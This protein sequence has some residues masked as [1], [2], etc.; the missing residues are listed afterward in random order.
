MS[1]PE[2]SLTGATLPLDVEDGLSPEFREALA[3]VRL[4]GLEPTLYALDLF[5]RSS[6]GELTT[7]DV[8]AQLLAHHRDQIRQAPARRRR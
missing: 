2:S 4:E 5:R 1:T 6:A 3:S 7:A 8:H